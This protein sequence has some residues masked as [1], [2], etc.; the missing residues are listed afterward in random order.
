MTFT[1]T[2]A[3]KTSKIVNNSNFLT[4]KAKLAFL[5]LIKVFIKGLVFDYSNAKLLENISDRRFVQNS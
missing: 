4:L 1:T 3:R 5:L 2:S